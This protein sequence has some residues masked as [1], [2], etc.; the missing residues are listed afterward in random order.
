VEQ[1]DNE[2]IPTLES[3]KKFIPAD[4]LWPINEAWYVHA[5]AIPGAN[6]LADVQQ[7]VNRRYGPSSNVAEFVLKAQLAGYENTRAQFENFAAGDWANHKVAMYWMLN[8]HWPSFYSNL[9]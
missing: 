9:I 7:T 2:R 5:G 6:T 1:G 3:L 8:S 4:K